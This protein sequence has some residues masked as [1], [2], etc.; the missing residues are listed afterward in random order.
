M[1]NNP[2]AFVMPHYNDGN[3]RASGFLEDSLSAIF[4]QTDDNWKLIIIDD[5]SPSGEAKRFLVKLQQDNN[6]KV[7][8]IFLKKNL[9]AGYCRNI[10]IQVAQ[11]NNYPVIMFNDADDISN[12]DRL[13]ITRQ[14]LSFNNSIDVV[15]STF[16][17]IDENGKRID[18]NMITPS[19]LEILESHK[20][21]PQGMEIW[22]EIGTKTGYINLTSSTSVRTDL[23]TKQLFPCERISE[24]Y[25]TWI[26]YSAF[27]G[28]FIFAPD[29]P[30]QY[31]IPSYANGSSSRSKNVRF[32][33]KK[34]EIDTN[35]FVEALRLARN[36]GVIN[37]CEIDGLLVEFFVRL[38]ETL[39]KESAATAANKVI[40]KSLQV[41]K[42]MTA[43][44]VDNNL[45]LKPLLDL[46]AI[47]ALS[48]QQQ[49]NIL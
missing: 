3:K 5:F 33:E 4:S 11:R 1:N 21:P 29:I 23:A 28:R 10:G 49:C 19:I 17:P 48:V 15:Y 44:C 9:G 20:Y 41:S 35:G 30:T 7:S 18:Y 14:I 13:K 16:F 27:G 24:D 2:Y 38:T 46:R 34:A 45:F 8:V 32:Y 6:D 37:E 22:R 25:H 47:P 39:L 31:R 43:R 12:I 42:S 26:R 40:L 36:R